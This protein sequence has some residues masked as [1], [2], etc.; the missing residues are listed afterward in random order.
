M[1]PSQVYRR[2]QKP[3]RAPQAQYTPQA[4]GFAVRKA[5]KKAGVPGWHPYQLRHVAGTRFRKE[6]GLEAAQVLLGHAKADVTQVY[7]ERN[8]KLGIKAARKSG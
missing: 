2:K 6:H 3:K 4:I 8:I 7:A 5:Y 1:Q